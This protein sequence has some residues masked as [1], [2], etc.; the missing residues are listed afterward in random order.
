MNVEIFFVDEPHLLVLATVDTVMQ[1]W[2]VIFNIIPCLTENRL[3]SFNIKDTD[4]R[5]YMDRKMAGTCT[6]DQIYVNVLF[7]LTIWLFCILYIML[8]T[9][10]NQVYLFYI[11]QNAWEQQI[12]YYINKINVFTFSFNYI[13]LW[14]LDKCLS[15]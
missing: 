9:M 8:S 15:S 2:E 6:K 4:F 12:V 14:N 11:G 10:L 3:K 1:H 7:I 13:L 5:N